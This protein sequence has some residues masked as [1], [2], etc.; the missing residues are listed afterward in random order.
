MPEIRIPLAEVAIYL[1]L[2]PK[3]NSAYHAINSALDLIEHNPVQKVPHHLTKLGSAN[4]KYPHD[5]PNHRVEQDYLSQKVKLYLP[6]SNKFESAA[7]EHL[8]K[9]KKSGL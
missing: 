5:Y 6:A 4:Y 2:S 1:A 8:S 9:I 3:S 7:Q